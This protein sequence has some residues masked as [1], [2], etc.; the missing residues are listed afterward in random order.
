MGKEIFISY[1]R[2]DTGSSAGRLYDALVKRLGSQRVFKDIDNIG[3]GVDFRKVIGKQLL[4]ARVILLL[5]GDRYTTLKDDSGNP[6]IMHEDDYVREEAALAL[7]YRKEK[8]IIPV[9][10]DGAKAPASD[11]LPEELK[12]LSFIN[13][14]TLSYDR[15]ADDVDNLTEHIKNYLEPTRTN[16]F[17]QTTSRNSTATNTQSKQ[18]KKKSNTP[19]LLT[20]AIGFL[21]IAALI[22][23]QFQ[24]NSD[25]DLE[26]NQP[27][28]SQLDFDGIVTS[29]GLNLRDQPGTESSNVLFSLNRDDMV[30]V[31][32]SKNFDD[33]SLWYFVDFEGSEGWVSSKHIEKSRINAKYV[34]PAVQQ[35]AA[36]SKNPLKGRWKLTQAFTDGEIDYTEP[37]GRQYVIDDYY[38]TMMPFNELEKEVYTYSLAGNSLIVD[39]VRFTANF[40][41]NQLQLYFEGQDDYGYFYSQ[42][43]YYQKL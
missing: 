24:K 16:S 38:L 30:E 19:I 9:F 11:D 37:I 26:P 32:G 4:G 15:W 2:K 28:V 40:A 13:G 33:G 1:R 5:I 42:T 34:E 17:Q 23:Y 29:N 27:Y 22:Y 18:I 35:P 41:T 8:L 25:Y 14:V 20:L 43:F 10:V 3:P 31:L 39:G 12:D 21:L 6:R 7:A 36:T